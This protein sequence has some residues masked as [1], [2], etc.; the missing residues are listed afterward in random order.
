HA[1][2]WEH[3]KVQYAGDYGTLCRLLCDVR[4]V[5]HTRLCGSYNNAFS[6]VWVIRYIVYSA[7]D[8]YHAYSSS[9]NLVLV[10]FSC[11]VPS[12]EG[13]PSPRISVISS[14]LIA[15]RSRPLR[16]SWFAL[17]LRSVHCGWFT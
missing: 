15:S 10:Y 9:L 4:G 14:F 5:V 8:V 2:L 16:S 12:S 17:W 6:P 3:L 11:L 7:Y 1:A 13:S